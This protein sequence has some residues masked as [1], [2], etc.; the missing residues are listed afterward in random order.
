MLRGAAVAVG[1]FV[2][3]DEPAGFFLEDD[4]NTRVLLK[5]PGLARCDG[6]A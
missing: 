1:K 2:S 4:A 5:L 3:V 6:A